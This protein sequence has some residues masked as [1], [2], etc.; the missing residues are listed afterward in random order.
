VVSAR[1]HGAAGDVGLRGCDVIAERGGAGERLGAGI[2]GLEHA[3]LDFDAGRYPRRVRTHL[4]YDL[5]VV[6][7]PEPDDRGEVS[8]SED[9]TRW[10][11]AEM[12]HAPPGKAG[13]IHSMRAR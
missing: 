5:A 7:Q 10:R 13:R 9:L 11:A 8:G 4:D 2:T 12:L 3:A 6:T 1:E